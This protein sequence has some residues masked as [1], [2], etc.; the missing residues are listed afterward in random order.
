MPFLAVPFPGLGFT[1]T[2]SLAAKTIA[3]TMG[4]MQQSPM[5]FFC[6]R[7]CLRTL[8]TSSSTVGSSLTPKVDRFLAAPKPPGRM[9][10][11]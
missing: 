2:L 9:T 5:G 4:A 7:N 8:A 11:A 10:A 6:S 3:A 1:G